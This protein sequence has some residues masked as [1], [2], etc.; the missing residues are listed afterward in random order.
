MHQSAHTSGGPGQ[1]WV[2]ARAPRAELA[3]Y[4]QLVRSHW[5]MI[6]AFVAAGLAAAFAYTALAPKTYKAEAN[7]LV[8]PVSSDDPNLVGLPLVR[9]TSDPTADV[10][11]VAQ[12]ASSPQVA[13]LV[14]KQVGGNPTALL[15]HITA[16]PVT[17]SEIIAVQATASRPARAA[18]L[19]NAFA[20]Q[21]VQTRT[22]A[23]HAQLATLIPALK[24]GMQGLPPGE[25]TGLESQLAVF[26]T[27]QVSPD[28]TL[29]VSSLASKP[30]AP[31]SKRTL[32]IGAGGFAG[33]VLGLLA[34][35][36]L[37]ALDPKLRD[38]E[39]LREVFDLPVLTRVPRQRAG[40]APL[41]PDE[42]TAPVS[43]AFRALRA[44]FTLKEG[45]EG[46]GHA[47]VVSGDSAGDG[48][49]T[50]ALNLAASLVAAGKQVMLIES[51]MRRP[52][53]GRALKLRAPH[54]LAEI[55]RG[56]IEL[57]DAVVWMQ[58][59][60]P[61]LEFLLAGGADA[62]D[63][64]R[65][66]PASVSKLVHDACSMCDF[67]VID[68][69]PLIDVAEALPFAR[70]ADDVLLVARVGNSHIRKMSDLGELL[71][72]EGIVP[73]GVVL[74]GALERG[75]G[76][77]YRYGGGQP[78]L[79]GMLQRRG[80]QQNGVESNGHQ[81]GQPVSRSGAEEG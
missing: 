65:I 24:A 54:G 74:V 52:S 18:Q 78:A 71:A 46:P 47:I 23:M 48:K 64:D 6:V 31:T 1:S 32:A 4:V 80:H 21:T 63:I 68:A 9:E 7:L 16:T 28:P 72:R 33:L 45:D 49:T 26:E 39:Q 59:F 62:R 37:Q 76:Y 40:S 38:E 12:L 77:Y 35:L 10:L 5:V 36:A 34:V 8:T 73:A 41:T 14:A 15:S 30:T 20:Q 17:Q 42:L 13:S 66:S 29:R 55:L 11:T 58:P 81:L 27:L 69:P 56:R 70:E 43:D 53:I 57:A 60:G 75:G 2:G 50:V 3:R 44:G 51:D 19:A 79:F 22:D 61:Q 25:D 67:V